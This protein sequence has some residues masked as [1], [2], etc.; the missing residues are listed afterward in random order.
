MFLLNSKS[1]LVHPEPV[2]I[3]IVNNTP[4]CGSDKGEDSFIHSKM[5]SYTITNSTT[6]IVMVIMVVVMVVHC[7]NGSNGSSD[8][9]T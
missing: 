1:L 6:I 8:G 3:T 7:S 5:A 2:T 9:S 4:I